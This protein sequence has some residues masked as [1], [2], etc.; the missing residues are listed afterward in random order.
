Y[1]TVNMPESSDANWDWDDFVRRNNNE[2][3]ATWG[4]LANRVLS[5][6]AKHWEGRVPQAG[7]LRPQDE[8]LLAIIE[9]G[10]DSVGQLIENVKLRGALGEAMRLAAEVNRYL[11]EQAPWTQVK[12]DKDAAGKTIYTALR[13]I[14]NL[15]LLLAPFLP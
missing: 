9:A 4:N 2:L 3:V 1:L 7:A 14:D 5:F 13:A 12:T 6:A 10:Y 8:A 11:D 15:K